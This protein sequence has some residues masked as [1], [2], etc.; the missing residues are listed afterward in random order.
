M[1]IGEEAFQHFSYLYIK[2]VQIFKNLEDCYDQMVHP[3]KR[4]SVACSSLCACSVPRGRPWP[5]LHLA[6]SAFIRC[7]VARQPL[8][9]RLCTSLVFGTA[10]WLDVRKV[11]E[12]TMGRMLEIRELLLQAEAGG[13]NACE[14]SVPPCA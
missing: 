13:A 10:L 8:R 5:Q 11:L 4:Q 2:Y 9:L 3:Q 7:C 6:G 1:Q 14:Y 12:A